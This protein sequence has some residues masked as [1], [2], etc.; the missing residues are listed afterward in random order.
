MMS[1][2][3]RIVKCPH[4]HPEFGRAG[5]GVA[6]GSSGK[7]IPVRKNIPEGEDAACQIDAVILKEERT[8]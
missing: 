3:G 5:L 1:G 2:N 8:M 4:T 7:D 6:P